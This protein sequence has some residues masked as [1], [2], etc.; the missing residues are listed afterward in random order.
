MLGHAPPTAMT[1]GKFQLLRRPKP[2]DGQPVVLSHKM[3]TA[4]VPAASVPCPANM[5]TPALVD[6]SLRER[7]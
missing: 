1:P 3:P 4:S 7:R 5:T 6:D 2:T